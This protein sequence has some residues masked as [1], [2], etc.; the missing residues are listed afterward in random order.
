MIFKQGDF[1]A[2]RGGFTYEHLFAANVHIKKGSGPKKNAERSKKNDQLL[3][4]NLGLPKFDM[5]RYKKHFP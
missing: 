2:C 4:Q 5:K 1:Q 3:S